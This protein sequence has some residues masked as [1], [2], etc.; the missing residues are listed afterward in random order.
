M[1]GWKLLQHRHAVGQQI[2]SQTARIFYPALEKTPIILHLIFQV[3]PQHMR[4][5]TAEQLSK[6]W[7]KYAKL[8]LM[9]G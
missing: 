5:D 3:N 1:D 7:L 4:K 2:Q 9:D 6:M 8:I